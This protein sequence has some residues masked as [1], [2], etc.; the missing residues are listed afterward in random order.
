ML[1]RLAPA[2]LVGLVALAASGSGSAS[3]QSQ[4]PVGV[5][6]APLFGPDLVRPRTWV[7]LLVTLENRTTRSFQGEV[8]LMVKAWSS[9]ALTHETRVDLPGGATRRVVME[10]YLP[11]DGSEIRTEYRVDGSIAG[12][13]AYNVPYSSS[14]AGIVVLARESRLRS[15][16]GDVETTMEDQ[17]G[18]VR[19]VNMPVGSVTFDATTG[20]PITPESPLGYAPVAM[21][22]ARSSELEALSPP[23][24]EALRHW[25]A[26]GGKL[27]VFPRTPEAVRQPF[28]RSL[29]G[30]LAFERGAPPVDGPAPVPLAVPDDLQSW[31]WVPRDDSQWLTESFGG[32]RRLGFG[33][34]YLATY[35]GT[36]PPHVDRGYTPAT[37]RAVA[38]YRS[39]ANRPMLPFAAPV[40]QNLGL[41][42]GGGSESGFQQLR[43]ALDPNESFRPALGLVALLLLVYVVLVGPVNFR[44]VARKNRPIFALVTTPVLALGCLVLMLA[45]GYIGKGVTMRYRSV[46][47]VDAVAGE[48]LGSAREYLSFFLTRPSSF[49]LDDA[50]GRRLLAEGSP[51]MPHIVMD[52]EE[53]HMEDLQGGLWQSLFL[54]RDATRD[55]GGGI[56]FQVENQRLTA[57]DN[58][59]SLTLHDAILIAPG[60]AIYGVGDIAP[61]SSAPIGG[62]PIATIRQEDFY[63]YGPNQSDVRALGGALGMNTEEG[64][65]TLYGLTQLTGGLQAPTPYLLARLEES[66]GEIAGFSEERAIDLLRVLVPSPEG[67]IHMPGY[68]S[69]TTNVPSPDLE[70]IDLAPGEPMVD[71]PEDP[72]ADSGKD[73]P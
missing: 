52:G 72:F 38:S 10:V 2:L 34:V 60:G 44:W 8:H 32:S 1:E 39:F 22:V 15:M 64:R 71:G 16:L 58:G 36:V 14:G 30:E 73:A 21:V 29:V 13:T 66:E 41:G 70:P 61:G 24:A 56:T 47:L 63:Y 33:R 67:P 27:F 5:E 17:Y 7:A 18:S 35:D 28:L 65:Q 4:R 45:V 55:L 53:Q 42:F 59:S 26:T 62:Q 51:R 20:D 68:G 19:Q 23:Q 6:V 12:R 31:R 25:V 49:D 54:R 43:S 3:A 69:P 50:T 11:E 37:L 40:D 48:P 57:V 9:D 46:E